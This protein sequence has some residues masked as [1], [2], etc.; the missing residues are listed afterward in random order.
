VGAPPRARCIIAVSLETGLYPGIRKQKR[1]KAGQ[2][3]WPKGWPSVPLS[4][5]SINIAGEVLS[6]KDFVCKGAGIERCFIRDW[7]YPGD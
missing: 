6:G 5:G 4:A 7:L 3:P 2:A 1:Q